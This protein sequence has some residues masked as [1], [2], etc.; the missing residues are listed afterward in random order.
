MTDE[1][2]VTELARLDTMG[3]DGLPAMRDLLRP[4]GQLSRLISLAVRGAGKRKPRAPAL[5]EDQPK[6]A[7]RWPVDKAV[8]SEWL[9]AAAARRAKEGLPAIDLKLT[10]AEFETYWPTVAGRHGA[11]INWEMTF[12]NRCL[13]ARAPLEPHSRFAVISGGKDKFEPTNLQGWVKRLEIFHGL[14]E[15]VP[16]AEWPVNRWGSISDVPAEAVKMFESVHGRRTA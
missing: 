13:T 8:P 6:R 11:K 4:A 2:L 7:T 16:G 9:D 5:F 14:V 3:K 12:V 15:G 10:A 1:D